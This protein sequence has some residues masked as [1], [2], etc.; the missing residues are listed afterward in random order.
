MSGTPTVTSLGNNDVFD[1]IDVDEIKGVRIY[2]IGQ[3][4]AIG[5]LNENKDVVLYVDYGGLID[6]PD[7]SNNYVD[8][9]LRLP[10]FFNQDHVP[11][12]L[13]HWDKDHY[14]SAKHVGSIRDSQWV[15]PDQRMGVQATNFSA[16]LNN[17]YTW[18]E[19][20]LPTVLSFFANNGD[21]LRIEK[22][23]PKPNKKKSEDRN[24]TGLAIS[25]IKEVSDDT[26]Q[27]IQLPGDAPYHK[28]PEFVDLQSD[29]D[30]EFIGGT[31]YH[32]G[33]KSHW[34]KATSN[35]LGSPA[36]GA[37]LLF[38]Y[39]PSNSYSHPQMNNYSNL[40]WCNNHIDETPNY[41]YQKHEFVDILF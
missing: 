24:L 41:Q 37:R 26:Y 19:T 21:E 3:G 32:H 9:H 25:I 30:F 29:S 12:I 11:V 27:F 7:K 13:T 18:P 36:H 16:T 1:N 2:Y 23:K 4:D 38:S 6:H 22:I 20:D 8:T 10:P 28:I 5:I 34:T 15:F 14:Y 33:A 39:G 35:V 40:R 31:A 17:A